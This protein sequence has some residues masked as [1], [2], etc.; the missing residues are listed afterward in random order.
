MSAYYDQATDFAVLEG[1]G[2]GENYFAKA[3][4]AAPAGANQMIMILRHFV[5]YDI[6]DANWFTEN[7]SYDN[8]MYYGLKFGSAAAVITPQN[9]DPAVSQVPHADLLGAYQYPRLSGAIGDLSL[10]RA[11]SGPHAPES[12]WMNYN[13]ATN[14][15]TINIMDGSGFVGGRPRPLWDTAKSPLPRR[16]VL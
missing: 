8:S 15:R 6:V 1:D 13:D 5:D 4:P 9:I 7:L 16:I 2:F 11:Q 10:G 12:N 3:L 14:A